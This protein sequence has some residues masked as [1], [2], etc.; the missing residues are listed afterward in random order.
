MALVT[1]GRQRTS[2]YEIWIVFRPATDAVITSAD[3]ASEWVVRG[4]VPLSDLRAVGGV[5]RERQRRNQVDVV[6]SA[7]AWC[8][9]A[10][11]RRATSKADGNT[12]PRRCA[13]LRIPAAALGLKKNR[14]GTVVESS[15][16]DDNE[17]ATATLG[18]S[19]ILAIENPV[20]ALS[21]PA[22]GQCGKDGVKISS[23]VRRKQP[24]NIFKHHPSRF[25][26][27]RNP[28]NLPEQPRPRADESFALTSYA[29]VLTREPSADYIDG[30]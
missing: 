28:H 2:H 7:S 4:V 8:V 18:D 26:F 9:D 15:S 19:E 27:S 25:E 22:V 6:L 17:H 23:S 24:S 13:R 11:S 30:F 29:H 16:T 21:K 10:K 14:A 20:G 5:Q 12:R 1:G 3:W